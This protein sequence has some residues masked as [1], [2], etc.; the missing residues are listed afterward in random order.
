MVIPGDSPYTYNI[1]EPSLNGR[2][3]VGQ[4]FQN[5]IKILSLLKKFLKNIIPYKNN[6]QLHIKFILFS[7]RL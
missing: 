3:M 1:A 2:K 7:Y 4:K 5:S 6:T